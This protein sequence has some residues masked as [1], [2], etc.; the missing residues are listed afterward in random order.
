LLV[1]GLISFSSFIS[2]LFTMH[3][4]ICEISL[5]FARGSYQ[6]RGTAREHRQQG[7]C[8]GSGSQCYIMMFSYPCYNPCISL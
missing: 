6:A 3:H 5:G 7:D 8:Q 4:L 1:C 2:Q